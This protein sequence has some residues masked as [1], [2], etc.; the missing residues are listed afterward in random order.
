MSTTTCEWHFAERKDN[1]EGQGPNSAMSQTFAKFPCKS[2]VRESIQNSLDAVLDKEKPVTVCFEYRTFEKTDEAGFF[3][4]EEHIKAGLDKYSDNPTAQRSYP[5]MLSILKDKK[6]LGFIRISDFNTKGMDYEKGATNKTFYA[7]VRA[8]GVSVK[9]SAGTGGSFGFGKGAFFVMSPIN[10][11]I[12]STM[13][14]DNKCYFEGVSRLC[15]HEYNGTLRSPMGFYDCDDGFPTTNPDN[16]P[17][18]FKRCQSGTSIGI[19]GIDHDRWDK[20]KEE[21]VKEVLGN[22]F[23][24]I[25]R[26]KLVVIIDGNIQD[27]NKAIVIDHENIDSLMKKYFKDTIDIRDRED[28]KFNPRPYYE[29][30][31]DN[32]NTSKHYKENLPTL[33]QVELYL[34]YFEGNST[35]IIFMRKLLMKVGRKSRNLGNF[36][37]VFICENESGN[38]ILA[39]MEGPEHKEWSPEHCGGSEHKT[40]TDIKTAQ[41]A[42]QEFEGFVNSCLEKAM[43]L[44]SSESQIV[45]GLEKYLPS[46][47]AANGNGEKGNP[48]FGEP[49]G[50]YIKEGASLNTEGI[51]KSHDNK[52][53]KNKGTVLDISEGGFSHRVGGEDNGGTG[54]SNNGNGG[55]HSGPGNNFGPGEV[56]SKNGRHKCMVEVDWRPVISQK[57]GYMDIII[58]P[59]REIANAELHF[60]IGREGSKG[61][62][63]EEDVYITDTNKGKADKLVVTDVSLMANAKNI[64]QVSFS[65]K[66]SHTL[67]LGVYETY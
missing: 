64:I 59:N 53:T 18:S 61:R 38:K 49:T 22:F 14:D 63:P 48:F 6:E 66:M 35:N 42:Y 15:T 31:T 36:N 25:L 55:G 57:K 7:F 34:K 33:G 10:T 45:V 2:L 54:G 46:D 19:M 23:V 4:L 50:K 40:I 47:D 13:T 16:I 67:T 56:T 8:Q 12:V 20:S 65:D 62:N 5:A 60:S 37:G 3:E 43:D 21:L 52:P 9:E 29:A 26:N 41:K 17:T 44:N 1:D 27:H 32:E 11:I 51:I 30:I 39:D 58:F 28:N 24:A